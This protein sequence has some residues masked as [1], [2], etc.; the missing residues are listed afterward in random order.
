M[1]FKEHIT[2]LDMKASYQGSEEIIRRENEQRYNDERNKGFYQVQTSSTP[3]LLALTK[4]SSMAMQLYLLLNHMATKSNCVVASA[5]ALADHMDVS[6]ASINRAI[7]TLAKHEFV[8]LGRSG[9]T[10]MFFLNPEITWRAA[11]NKKWTCMFDAVVMTSMDEVPDVVQKRVQEFQ[12][13]EYKQ[14][15]TKK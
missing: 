8:R 14:M 12:E 15:L 7:R 5:Q 9:T 3:K 10:N 6:I 11:A 4:E 2:T 13:N 1:N